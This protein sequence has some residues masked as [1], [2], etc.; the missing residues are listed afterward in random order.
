MKRS[1]ALPCLPLVLAACAAQPRYVLVQEQHPGIE[2][3]VSC[4]A[5]MTWNICYQKAEEICPGGYT[6]LS[7][8]ANHG[9]NE[10]F[11]HCQPGESQRP[12]V[13]PLL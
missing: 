3:L 11:V 9:R 5:S 13:A 6:T 7:E 8:H 10:L 4:A 12:E 1:L 2:H